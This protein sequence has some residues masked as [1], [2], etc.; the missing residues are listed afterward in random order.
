LELPCLLDTWWT[1]FLRPLIWTTAS[2]AITA[3]PKPAAMFCATL[4]PSKFSV[5]MNKM[6]DLKKFYRAIAGD[7]RNTAV[8]KPSLK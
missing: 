1:I 5:P 8:L 3:K 6:D 2:P 4:A 7:E